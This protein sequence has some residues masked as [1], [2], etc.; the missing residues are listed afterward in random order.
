MIASLKLENFKNFACETLRAGP[1]TVIVG[2]NASGKSNVRDAFRFLHGI[3]R[4]YTLA[5]ILGGKFGP[6][7][8]VEWDP[9][10]GAPGEIAR[11]GE[12][13][14]SMTAE[15]EPGGRGKPRARYSISVESAPN[16]PTGFKVVAEELRY[17]AAEPVFTSRPPGADP[18]RWQ[19]DESHLLLRMAKTGERQQRGNRIKTRR[20]RPALTQIWAAKR[21]VEAHKIRARTVAESFRDMRFLDLAPERMREPSVPGSAVLGDGGE[22]LSTVLQRICADER[23]RKVLAGWTSELT[24][25]DV[26]DFEFPVDGYDGRIRLFIKERNGEKVSA[27][28]ASDGTLRFLAM[29]AALLDEDSAGLYFFEEIDNGIHPARLSLL[30]DLIERQTRKGGIQVV[31]TTHSPSFLSMIGDDTFEHASV[32][33]RLDDAGRA[34]VRPLGEIPNARELRGKQGL[35][36]LLDEGWMENALAFTENRR[37]NEEGMP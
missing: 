24:P 9:V 2:A 19:D 37:A 31:A 29:L 11:F 18:V 3:G 34:I 10:R 8:R 21:A 12:S 16:P 6:G 27:H 33:C 4:G 20:Y 17:G 23:K 28:S 22:N 15:I 5:E 32:V 35:G 25:M 26:E 7:G 13:A 14:F 30:I 1:F 36:P